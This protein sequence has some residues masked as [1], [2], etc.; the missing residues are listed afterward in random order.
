M[1]LKSKQ[2][3]S[4]FDGDS[5]WPGNLGGCWTS[6]GPWHQV[7][8]YP[9]KEWLGRL[10][11]WRFCFFIGDC[12]LKTLQYLETWLKQTFLNLICV[13]TYHSYISLK[14][15]FYFSYTLGHCQTALHPEVRWWAH[16][17]PPCEQKRHWWDGTWSCPSSSA[18]LAKQFV[19]R[20]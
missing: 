20:E 13:C 1:P 10:D 7:S 3:G 17:K 6:H 18:G 5:I 15:V 9:P 19:I 14:G 12:W 16:R 11:L 2:L 4:E 8:V